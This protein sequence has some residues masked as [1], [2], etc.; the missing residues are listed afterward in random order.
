[1]HNRYLGIEYPGL[2]T[3]IAFHWSQGA[4]LMNA[5][6]SHPV[7]PAE[8]DALWASAAML[9]LLAFGSFESKVADES[10][11]LKN[12]PMDLDWLKLCQGKRE[13]WK[14]ADPLREDSVFHLISPNF[15]GEPS[16][17]N[18]PR[19]RKLSGEL[20]EL[21]NLN[22]PNLQNN[23]PYLGPASFLAQTI[24]I[25]CDS[26]TLVLFL[27]FFGRI[28]E[29]YKRLLK[30]K[31][32]CALVLLAHWYAKMCQ[33]RQWWVW[34]RTVLECQAIC[35][36]LRLYHGDN[37]LILKASYAPDTISAAQLK[38]GMP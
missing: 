22:D 36:Y 24:D 8:Q 6:L 25:N 17:T 38:L 23:N 19:L 20:L 21:C 12:S 2:S 3:A 33:Y 16:S 32:P 34:P 9:G 5:I 27:S 1:M 11:P 7:G 28:G 15:L 29:D 13:I 18:D 26:E 35:K 14:I 4:A 37:H 30:E 31:D 10:W